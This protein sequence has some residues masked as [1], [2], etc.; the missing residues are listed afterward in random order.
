MWVNE[1]FSVIDDNNKIMGV[2]SEGLL[3]KRVQH[4][5]LNNGF[6]GGTAPITKDENG[7][8]ADLK[9]CDGIY[10]KNTKTQVRN[11]Q[12]KNPPL[13]KDGIVGKQTL[14]KMNQISNGQLS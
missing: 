8:K 14:D 13:S 3:V 7:C 4:F 11:F 5:L 9:K 12:I 1:D 10:G 6:S 2:G